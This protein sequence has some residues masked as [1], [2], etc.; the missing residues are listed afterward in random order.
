MTDNQ[1]I[2]SVLALAI[3]NI[4]YLNLLEANK[5]ETKLM[6]SASS[7]AKAP[8]D[9]NAIRKFSAFIS[10]VKHN[11]LWND[12][13]ITYKLMH[14]YA[15]EIE[16]F[17][18]YLPLYHQSKEKPLLDTL[19]KVNH[20]IQFLTPYL[21]KKKGKKYAVLFYALIHEDAIRQLKQAVNIILPIPKT[22]TFTQH[23]KLSINGAFYLV[24]LPIAPEDIN[25]WTLPEKK[26]VFAKTKNS[27]LYW[28][29]ASTLN[30]EIITL[31]TEA[32]HV[33]NALKADCTINSVLTKVKTKIDKATVLE[34]LS[35]LIKNKL[36]YIN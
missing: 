29:R 12:F 27:Y 2:Q 23:S 35:F 31:G 32:I 6:H 14:I 36:L 11:F 21:Q 20:F 34:I 1:H 7:K 17:A 22:S 26:I 18:D 15:L 24:K 5:D 33:L 25:E 10:K 4:E 3:T 16:I 9:L 19:S 30:L 8:N 28:R 13:P